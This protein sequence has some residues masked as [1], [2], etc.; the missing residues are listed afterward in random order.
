MKFQFDNT[1]TIKAEAKAAESRIR[2]ESQFDLR[3]AD[4]NS[5]PTPV[6]GKLAYSIK[7]KT[8]EADTST[9]SLAVNGRW[10]RLDEWSAEPW[11]DA[12]KASYWEA[13]G[14]AV[15]NAEARRKAVSRAWEELYETPQRTF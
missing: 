13:R 1:E 8:G 11:T 2:F 4:V 15:A 6:H 12:E 3:V 10:E 7:G 9:G 14:K 5:K